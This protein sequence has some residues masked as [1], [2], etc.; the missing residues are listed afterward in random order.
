MLQLS[1]I[2]HDYFGHD[3]SFASFT[4]MKLDRVYKECANIRKAE[5]ALDKSYNDLMNNTLNKPRKLNIKTVF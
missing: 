5:R 1:E 3:D 4:E 2:T